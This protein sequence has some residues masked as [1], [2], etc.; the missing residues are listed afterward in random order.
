MTSD[1]NRLRWRCRRGMREM[2]IILERY[3]SRG[4][5]CASASERQAFS[6]M[7]DLQDPELYAL[8]M[9]KQQPQTEDWQRLLEKIGHS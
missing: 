7:L 1:D 6:D 5:E 9:G 8:L 2:D 3:L 4:Y